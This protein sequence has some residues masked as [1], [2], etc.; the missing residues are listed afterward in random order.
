LLVCYK[1]LFVAVEL[2]DDVGVPSPQQL[3]FIADVIEAEGKGAICR[4]LSE[5][6]NLL[7][8]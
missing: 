6:F 1:G 3:K 2:K 8:S 5:V 4:T 7:V